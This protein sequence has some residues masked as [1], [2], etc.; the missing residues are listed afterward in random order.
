MP[1]HADHSPPSSGH[2]YVASH[3]V[4]LSEID[5]M[6][7]IV[8]SMNIAYLASSERITSGSTFDRLAAERL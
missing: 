3:K 7:L 5:A 8:L 4:L 1:Q 6:R 2:S